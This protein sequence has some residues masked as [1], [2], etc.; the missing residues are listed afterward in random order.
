MR[1]RE[2]KPIHTIGVGL[3]VVAGGLFS[4]LGG[5]DW[6]RIQDTHMRALGHRRAMYEICAGLVLVAIGGIWSWFQGDD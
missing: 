3:V 5:L 2:L 6:L 4:L 1:V